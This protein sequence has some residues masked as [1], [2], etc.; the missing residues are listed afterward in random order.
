MPRGVHFTADAGVGFRKVDFAD[1]KEG[2]IEG[3]EITYGLM[4]SRAPNEV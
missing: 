2:V 3:A 1:D 4:W